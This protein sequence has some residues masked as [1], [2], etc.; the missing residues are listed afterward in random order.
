MVVDFVPSPPSE[1]IPLQ[2]PS[3]AHSSNFPISFV[4]SA[5]C[6]NSDS[7][8]LPSLSESDSAS[9]CG[10]DAEPG[11]QVCEFTV[12]L[13]DLAQHKVFRIMCRSSQ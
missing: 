6:C 4:H 5:L 13:L 1:T 12:T 7:E 9:D 8:L 11:S 2:T 3:S 10:S